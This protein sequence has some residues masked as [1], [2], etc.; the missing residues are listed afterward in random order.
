LRST[1]NGR[2]GPQSVIIKSF[3]TGE[4]ERRID[5]DSDGNVTEYRW[6]KIENAEHGVANDHKKIDHEKI[7]IMKNKNIHEP[8]IC[9]P[10]TR[11]RGLSRGRRGRFSLCSAQ[12]SVVLRSA[13]RV[14]VARVW[15]DVSTPK[16]ITPPHNKR[17]GHPEPP[18]TRP[19]HAEI[20]QRLPRRHN[21]GVFWSRIQD[22][23][24]GHRSLVR[25]RTNNLGGWGGCRLRRRRGPHK[26]AV[27]PR[28]R[29]PKGVT[30]SHR[31]SVSQLLRRETHGLCRKR[32]RRKYLFALSAVTIAYKPGLPINCE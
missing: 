5:V 20:Q 32:Q 28:R 13:H 26:A 30:G 21:L 17:G 7:L 19:P 9:R 23:L 8:L 4:P 27:R 24:R 14:D 10:S 25:R 12:D 3:V 31:H 2:R 11:G 6:V 15:G 1:L 29:R 18:R 16:I 22:N